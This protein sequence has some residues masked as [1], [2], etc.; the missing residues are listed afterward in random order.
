MKKK[1]FKIKGEDQKKVNKQKFKKGLHLES[2]SDLDFSPKNIV[3]FK[4]VFTLNLAPTIHCRCSKLSNFA[5]FFSIPAQKIS[6][7]P[8]FLNLW[9]QLLPLQKQLWSSPNISEKKINF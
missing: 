6:L 1:L 8:K 5:Q 7:F 2:V 9:A 4:K 3:I